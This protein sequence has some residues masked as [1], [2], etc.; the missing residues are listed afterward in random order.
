M[1]GLSAEKWVL[2]LCHGYGAP[3]DGVARQW[4]AL[5]KGTEYRV[6]TVFLTG[7]PSQPVTDL[8]GSDETVFLQYDSSE[9]RGLKRRQIR[10]IR[11]LHA[12]YQF[13]LT[14]A[15]RY[16]PIYIATHLPGVPVYGVA[17]AYDV[18]E[19][20][21]RRLFVTRH[22]QQLHLIA[23]SD[24]VRSNIVADLPKFAPSRIHTVYNRID[25]AAMQPHQLDRQQARQHLGVSDDA[26]VIGNVGRLHPDKD[27]HTLLKGF[28][29]ALP[30]LDE[31]ACLV[32]IGT[33]R[34]DAELK[35][36]ADTL[37]IR[38]RVHFTGRVADAWKYFKAF[39]VFAL[40]SRNEPFG[41]VVLEA[42][43]AEV[44]V[45][46]ADSGGAPEIVGD[47]GNVFKTGNPESL[48]E[49][50]RHKPVFNKHLHERLQQRFSDQAVRQH[51]WSLLNDRAV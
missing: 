51:F 9:L 11:R 42:L 30:D 14:I 27:Q 36:L 7:E 40:S 23:V 26:Y 46:V 28:A 17:H 47:T 13:S 3:F 34:L 39:D 19:G 50:L 10:D 22:Q 35:Q 49:A 32:V 48:A 20:F 21:W 24:A 38:D 16:K 25:V 2:Q 44:P 1:T 12:Q 31:K 15:H 29:L 4:A 6:L 37:G 41:M 18:F 45:V 5:F 8:V 43:A 33:G